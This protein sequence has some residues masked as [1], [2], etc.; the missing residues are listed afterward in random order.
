MAAQVTGIS[1]MATR[2]ILTELSGAYRAKT[3]QA[4][5]IESVGGV[6]AAKRVRAGEAFDVVVLADD[7]LKQLEADGF[8]KASSRTGFARSA[9]AVAIRAG[10]RR[11]DLASEAAL[12]AAVL[13]AKSIGYSTGPSGTHVLNL[14][15]TWGI[16]QTVAERLVKASPGIAVGT[17]VARGE[18]ELGFQQLSEFLDVPGIEIAGPLPPEVQSV[19]LFTCG[20][21]AY[22]TNE[23]GARALINFLTSAEAEAPIRR[24]GMEPA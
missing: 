14:L 22:A 20:V 5:A 16:E 9:M 21:C 12:K 15:K 3:G 13:A 18:A 11:P 17:L 8:L 6:D 7:A 24:Q 19:T 23:A 2:Q 1:S 10:A 4:V